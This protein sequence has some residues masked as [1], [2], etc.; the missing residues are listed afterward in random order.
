[1][2]PAS[3]A[4]RAAIGNSGIFGKHTAITSPICKFSFVCKRIASAAEWSRRREYVYERPVMP[5][6]WNSNRALIKR[7][8]FRRLSSPRLQSTV[9]CTLYSVFQC[10]TCN[11][12]YT[13]W[14]SRRNFVQ[15]SYSREMLFFLLSIFIVWNNFHV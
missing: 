8:R 7:F 15:N 11:I 10:Q 2:R 13:L 14:M 5:H 3:I 1:M 6:T 9:D 12:I 4:P